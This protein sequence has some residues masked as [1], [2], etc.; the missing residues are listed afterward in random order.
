MY[1]TA[2]LLLALLPAADAPAADPSVAE[3]EQAVLS[4]RR[5]IQRGMVSLEAKISGLNSQ[6]DEDR[7]TTFW[8]DYE[9]NKIRS[10]VVNHWKNRNEPTYRI[11]QCSNCE[12]PNYWVEYHNKPLKNAVTSITLEPLT[13][14]VRKERLSEIFDPRMLGLVAIRSDGL[15]HNHFEST[16]NSATRD[17]PKLH[18]DRWK[19]AD[20]WV[21]SFRIN[22]RANCELWVVPSHGYNVARN[23]SESLENGGKPYRVTVE[24]E[25]APVGDSGLWFPRTCT[26]EAV[27]DGKLINKEVLRVTNISLNE[28][29]DDKVFTLAGMD[30]AP[31]TP[32]AGKLPNGQPHVWTWTGTSVV[33]HVNPKFIP[34][35][36]P[37]N[38][39][40]W[41]I[42][43]AVACAFV[44]TAALAIYLRRGRLKSSA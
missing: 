40:G 41:L 36:P 30:I 1:P 24:T 14:E 8:F 18:R 42:A 25:A 10:D 37:P 19:G 39:R 22:R 43:A 13:D 3:I 26:Y 31:D 12:R 44:A 11:I 15:R 21:I 34:A 20:C 35:P 9:K 32:I 28:P 23:I 4:R 16:L 38:K 17:K 33:D 2:F 5:S 6:F 7:S 29:I 27:S